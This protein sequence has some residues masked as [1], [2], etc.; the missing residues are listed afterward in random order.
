MNAM[1][2]IVV[3]PCNT[4]QIVSFARLCLLQTRDVIASLV[5]TRENHDESEESE[6]SLAAIV[7]RWH[8][9]S[10]GCHIADTIILLLSFTADSVISG[11]PHHSV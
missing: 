1:M 9:F 3:L 10:V 6:K 2:L 11:T 7:G 4:C 8:P 5:S